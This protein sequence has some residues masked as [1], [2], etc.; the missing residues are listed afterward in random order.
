M[1]GLTSRCTRPARRVRERRRVSANVSLSEPG[2]GFADVRS[3]GRT[4]PRPLRGLGS[5][6]RWRSLGGRAPGR[7]IAKS[8]LLAHSPGSRT[9]GQVAI[10]ALAAVAL[11]VL[12][13]SGVVVADVR[14]VPPTFRHARPA[15]FGRRL[16]TAAPDGPARLCLKSA[17]GNP[18]AGG[19]R[20]NRAQSLRPVHRAGRRWPQGRAVPQVSRGR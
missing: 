5:P 18:R 4:A 19:V 11:L 9:L 13:G 14:I 12:V 10:V 6:Q 8:R 1:A 15:G 16:T 20:G 7:R 17:S 3:V 2:S